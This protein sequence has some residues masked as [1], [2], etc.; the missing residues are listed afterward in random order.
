MRYRE[1]ANFQAHASSVKSL[2][3]HYDREQKAIVNWR[4]GKGGG[5][6]VAWTY[7]GNRTSRWIW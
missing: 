3:L 4:Y 5:P 6:T 1:T 7:E 2:S